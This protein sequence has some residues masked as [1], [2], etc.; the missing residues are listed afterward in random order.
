MSGHDVHIMALLETTTAYAL[1]HQLGDDGDMEE[2]QTRACVCT[3][4]ENLLFGPR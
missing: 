3:C 1:L 4:R 2:G